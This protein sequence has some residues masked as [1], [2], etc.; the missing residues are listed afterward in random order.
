MRVH[1]IS[2]RTIVTK[3]GQTSIPAP[4]RRA[5]ELE[6]GESLAWEIAT[7]GDI[8]VRVVRDKQRPDPEKML[9][10]AATFR[11]PQR[12]QEWMQLLREGER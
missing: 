7:N 11:R 5:L 10:F 1:M 12:T 2:T 4:I 3:R 8:I 9:G 6:T